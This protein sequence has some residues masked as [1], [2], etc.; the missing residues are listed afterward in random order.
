MRRFRMLLALMLAVTLL[1][2]A[3]GGRDE[4][5]QE[6]RP[7]TESLSE[8]GRKLPPEI[9][10][11]KEVR[12]G[13]DI[14][15]APIEFVDEKTGDFVGLDIDLCNAIVARFG[16]GF[17]CEFI[18]TPFDGLIEALKAKRFDIIMSSMTDTKERQEQG[19]DF[20]DYFSAGTAIIVAKGNPDGIQRL[21]DLCGKTIGVQKGTTQ[22]EVAAEQQKKCET[23]G[24][25]KLTVQLYDKDTDALEA[26]K[27]RR[28]VAD[29]NDFPVAAYNAQTADGGNAFEVV[30]EQFGAG[31]YGIV[32]RKE[33]TQ[34]RDALQEALKAIIADSAYDTILQKWSVEGGALKT[35]EI[36]G[37]G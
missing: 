11:R 18:N 8:L 32:V 37:G 13:S 3:C 34:L 9:Q 23:E 28:T 21:D 25:G 17:T 1:A 24:A 15:Y 31:P 26:L 2:A 36:N 7:K 10:V 16:E 12:V 14:A 19:V 33:D 20:I 5:G 4:E 22:A 35:A 6:E 27:A 29:L 30:G